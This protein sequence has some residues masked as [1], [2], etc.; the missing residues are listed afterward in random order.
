MPT[1]LTR[2]SHY[3][4][5][6]GTVHPIRH[7]FVEFS[8]LQGALSRAVAFDKAGANCFGLANSCVEDA[9]SLVS[10]WFS[11]DRPPQFRRRARHFTSIQVRVEPSR[12]TRSD[13][14][15]AQCTSF[16]TNLGIAERSTGRRG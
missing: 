7:F 2:Y 10:R 12:G 4:G 14:V 3:H 15:G 16:S 13:L 8:R 5:R 9:T 1:P 6:R 11:H